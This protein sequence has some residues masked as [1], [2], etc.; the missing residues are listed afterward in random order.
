LITIFPSF[1]S[2]FFFF[3]FR[4]KQLYEKFDDVIAS[5]RMIAKA[6]DVTDDGKIDTSTS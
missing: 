4:L 6:S 2:F 1:S 5:G 3:F